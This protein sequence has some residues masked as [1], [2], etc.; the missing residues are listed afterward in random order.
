MYQNYLLDCQQLGEDCRNVWSLPGVVFQ[1]G[2]DHRPQWMVLIQS[3]EVLSATLQLW[4]STNANH[5]D[6]R[7]LQS[8][9]FQHEHTEGEYI[10]FLVVVGW[11]LHSFRGHEG[12][13]PRLACAEEFG[14]LQPGL[15]KVTDLH[16]SVGVQQDVLVCE[17]SVHNG[18][19]ARVEELETEYDRN[20]NLQLLLST[21]MASVPLQILLQG[22]RH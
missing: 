19:I 5:T 10:Q 3:G 15:A 4:V 11:I 17:V 2:Q 13:R 16:H 22:L 8:G 12:D 7:K 20:T 6:T 1:T 14:S 9:Y 21:Q 18:W